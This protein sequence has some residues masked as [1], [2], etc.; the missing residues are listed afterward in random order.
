MRKQHTEL[1]KCDEFL[2]KHEATC[3]GKWDEVAVWFNLKVAAPKLKIADRKT[4]RKLERK[5]LVAPKAKAAAPAP[6]PAAVANPT[7][8]CD[9]MAKLFDV[10]FDHYYDE[11]EDSDYDEDD[12]ED[13]QEQRK[14]T[15]LEMA[16][17]ASDSYN[18]QRNQLLKANKA[19]SDNRVA[20]DLAVAKAVQ[21]LEG[22]IVKEHEKVLALERQLEL[23]QDDARKTNKKMDQYSNQITK[24]MELLKSNN[25]DYN[26]YD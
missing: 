23:A 18:S 25:I 22:E 2:R 19:K 16:K 15:L 5:T 17:K 21:D 9:Q 1:N 11:V 10:V 20:I 26:P 6:A 7:L 3:G 13:Y 8:S 12:L 24:I 14:L 4:D